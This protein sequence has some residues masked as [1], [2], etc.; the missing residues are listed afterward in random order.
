M[1][2]EN[3]YDM[4][5]MPTC[6]DR[7]MWDVWASFYNYPTLT[8]AD[9]LGLFSIINHEPSSA[10]AVSRRLTIGPRATEALLAVLTSLGFLVQHQRKFH[11][12][13]TSRNYLLPESPYYWGGMMRPD[14]RKPV[15]I[16]I[17]EALRKDERVDRPR[18]TTEW[19]TGALDAE[20]V[21]EFTQAMHSMFL[22]AAMGVAHRGD[23]KAVTHLLDV[24]GGSGCFCIALALRY[25]DMRFTILEL[26]IVCQQAEEYAANYGL[27]KR[28]S[29]L[30][31]D[32][33]EGAWCAGHDAVLFSNILHDWDWQRCVDL[34]RKAYDSLP[35]KGRIYLH[36]MLLAEMKDGPLVAAFFSMKM[37]VATEGKQFTADELDRLLNH[38]GFEDVDVT[39]TYGYFSLI[40]ALKK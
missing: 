11:L 30:S 26:P 9:E 22:P 31:T 28:I 27:E 8:V 4:T 19:K 20:R 10:E 12:T 23:F 35:P 3:T 1:S 6:D 13:E 2:N 14:R 37:M 34:V 18:I 39:P 33:F 21:K 16:M 15:H 25:P 5:P 17:R 24:A 29:T 36:E 38:C 40:T 7:L 32:M